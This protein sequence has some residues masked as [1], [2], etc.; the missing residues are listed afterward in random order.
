VAITRKGLRQR[1]R[2]AVDGDLRFVHGFEKGGL[3][4]RRGAVDFVGE[5]HVGE[6]R[7]GTKFKI[8]RLGIVRR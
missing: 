4:A 1:E 3:R 5:D 8:A 2:F 6:D 7:A